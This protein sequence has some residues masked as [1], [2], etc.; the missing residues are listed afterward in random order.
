MQIITEITEPSEDE[1][2]DVDHDIWIGREATRMGF[3]IAGSIGDIYEDAVILIP[4]IFVFDWKPGKV[5]IGRVLKYDVS[6]GEIAHVVI[7][8]ADGTQVVHTVNVVHAC[9]FA[10][11]EDTEGMFV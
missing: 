8:I 2:Y 10:L 4:G 11:P 9:Y 5:K 6:H 3:P 7:Q 1:K